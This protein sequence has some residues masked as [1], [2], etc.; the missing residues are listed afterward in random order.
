MPK[1]SM[2]ADAEMNPYYFYFYDMSFERESFFHGVIDI[3]GVGIELVFYEN[4]FTD[5]ETITPCEIPDFLNMIFD[6]SLETIIEWN[7]YVSSEV[8]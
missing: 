3:K 7:Q 5:R 1:I 2:T 4:N 6:E 8:A